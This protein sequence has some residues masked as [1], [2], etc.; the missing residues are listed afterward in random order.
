MKYTVKT[1]AL[2]A[3]TFVMVSCASTN[4]QTSNHQRR[5][6]LSGGAPSFS[7]L[8]SEMDANQDGKLAKSE[9]KGP[10]QR[11]FSTID[12]DHDGFIAQSELENAPMPQR[13]KRTS[14]N[15]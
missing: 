7:Q 8:L 13:G 11:D 6:K 9:V 10:L 1:L 3:V 12:R 5:P 2:A 4:N 15:R 14:Q